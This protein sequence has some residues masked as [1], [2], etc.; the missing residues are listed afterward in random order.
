MDGQAKER[1]TFTLYRK[2]MYYNCYNIYAEFA[3]PFTVNCG[4]EYVRSVSES[5]KSTIWK[6]T[7]FSLS[8]SF[9]LRRVIS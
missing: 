3:I 6:S 8:I 7:E 5:T 9:A 2:I 4:V 1:P